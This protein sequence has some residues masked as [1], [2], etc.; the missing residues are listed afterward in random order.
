MKLPVRNL[1]FPIIILFLLCCCTPRKI[2]YHHEYENADFSGKKL[3]VV[4]VNGMDVTYE[5]DV[6]NEFGKGDA[7]V[8]I[9]DHMIQQLA[10]LIKKQSNFS[11]VH[12]IRCPSCSNLTQRIMG[13][14]RYGFA[15]SAPDSG[16][17][18]SAADDEADFILL[19]EDFS[20][21]SVL[22]MHFISYGFIPLAAI[23]S[24]PLVISA[25]FVFWDNQKKRAAAWGTAEGG[26]DG[27]AAVTKREWKLAIMA[28][29]RKLLAETP[30]LSSRDIYR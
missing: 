16:E 4:F 25:K 26:A 8:L 28:F 29:C 15:I 12:A 19:F 2:F 23:P 14:P 9:A 13:N 17:E 21:V 30:F 1:I 10:L 20:V 5:G 27:G 11:K 22:R 7:T 6:E 24:K 3:G 18:V